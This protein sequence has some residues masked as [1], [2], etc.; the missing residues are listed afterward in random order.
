MI[1]KVSRL[2]DS[3]NEP[4]NFIMTVNAG[5][6]PFD[7]WHYDRE[8]GG[9][10]II[11]EGCHF[12]DLLRY[13]SKA[14]IVSTK[15]ISVGK[16]PAIKYQHDKVSITLSFSDGSLGTILSCKWCTFFPGAAIGCFLAQGESFA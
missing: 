9:G 4:K 10:R 11:S 6:L 8:V 7:H 16:N 15:A 5:S 2:L 3:V 12:I 13:L 14:E 1:Q